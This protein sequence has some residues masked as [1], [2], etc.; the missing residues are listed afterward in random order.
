MQH[1]ISEEVYNEFN[2]NGYIIFKKAI[3]EIT[4]N[5]SLK[6]IEDIREKCERYD[7]PYYRRYQDIAIN[8]IYGIEHI[9]HPKI[10]NEHIFNSIKESKVLE[11]SSELL[12]DEE[13]FLSR[14]R[15]H[16]TKNISHSGKWHRDGTPTG[17]ADDIDDYLKKSEKEIMWVQATLPYYYE[18]GF[19][20]IPGS[21]KYSKNFIPTK[22][23]RGTKKILENEKRLILNPGD[24]LLF[25]PFLIHRGTCV[26]RKLKQRAHIHMRFARK[27]FSRYADR[28]IQ[29][30]DFFKNPVVYNN[31]NN[32]WK[33]SIDLTL[34]DPIKW[35]GDE[36]IQKKPN[37]LSI[38]FYMKLL[39]ILINRII[40]NLS[41]FYPFSQRSLENI[42]FIKYPFLK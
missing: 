29:D 27:K 9:F 14:N 36:I 32:T 17:N 42:N 26:G 37:L 41:R 6:A 28:Y 20:I 18:D 21:H 19:Y 33:K 38:R 34:D 39:L 4:I 31:A 22:S 23:I 1:L 3:N 15:I 10:Y 7:Y 35:Y 40:Y 30:K 11:I 5:K 13:I 12:K 8:D 16:C 24:L 25:N 2:D